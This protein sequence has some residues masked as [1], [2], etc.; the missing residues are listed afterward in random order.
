MKKQIR[1]NVF[2]TNSSMMH[3]LQI[4][5]KADYDKFMEYEEDDDWVW[6]RYDEVWLNKNDY[7]E[8]E[9]E[10][11]DDSFFDEESDYEIQELTTEHGD[12]VVAISRAKEDY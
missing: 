12:V 3:T 7:E 9:L 8:D 5:S 6:D 11:C 4:M 2:E 10:E 1:F